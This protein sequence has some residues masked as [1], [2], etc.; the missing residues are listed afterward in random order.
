MRGV[1]LYLPILLAVALAI[2]R[3]PDRRRTAGVLLAAAW[4]LPALLAVNLLAVR[5]GWWSFDLSGPTLAGM[6]AD[7]WIGWALLWGA[8]PLLAT[9]DRLVVAG[10]ALVAAD[11]VLM[12]LGQPV[13][14]LHRSWLAGEGLAVATGLVP[15]LL[16]GRW[17][18]RAEHLA[19][20]AGLQVAAFSGLLLF[21]LPSL[22]FAGTDE[23][24]AVLVA[25]PRWQFVVA[26]L[27]LAPAG[28]M[29]IQAVREFV[30]HG[31]TP[32]PLDPPPR[33]VTSGPYAYVANPMQLGATV[34]FTGWGILLG[35]P[36]VVAGAAMAA[37]FSAG[38]AS[39]SERSS[40]R[41]A[42][43]ATGVATGA[44]SGPG[45]RGGARRSSNRRSCTSPA[46]ASRATRSA[47]SSGGDRRSGWT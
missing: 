45:C 9:V 29:A 27:A 40:W 5:A 18:A 21:V 25:R 20:R 6:P 13:V 42:S 31:G 46:R 8:V 3:P 37:I 34:I 10:V 11:L 12:P 33:L 22:V 1:A 41:R 24:W 26:A 39:W 32:V 47:V 23:D 4:N 30:A 44:T 15:G 35:S 16:L 2:H 7:L 17:T 14:V 38:L 19:G 36:G 43:A 28:S